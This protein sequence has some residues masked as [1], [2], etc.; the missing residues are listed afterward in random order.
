MIEEIKSKMLNLD[1]KHPFSSGDF[2]QFFNY[3]FH[4][5]FKRYLDK[6]QFYHHLIFR[7]FEKVVERRAETISI[8][9]E[10]FL[11]ICEHRKIDTS[12][13]IDS[14]FQYHKTRVRK[15]TEYFP[16]LK[17]GEAHTLNMYNR[18]GG[19][20]YSH[21]LNTIN[22]ADAI[23]VDPFDLY[24]FCVTELKWKHSAYRAEVIDSLMF[25]GKDNIPYLSYDSVDSN[26]RLS[27]YNLIRLIIEEYPLDKNQKELAVNYYNCIKEL[28]NKVIAIEHKKKFYREKAL[29]SKAKKIPTYVDPKK[30]KAAL[31]E[32]AKLFHPDKNPSGL[33]LFKEFNKHYM[34]KDISN[35]VKM[36][37]D[38][39]RR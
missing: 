1:L 6:P 37:N 28:I 23:L 38:Y 32:G 7:E 8:D 16:S 20:Y 5:D 31:R 34:N 36:I 4:R 10:L 9:R 21:S 12:P 13:F 3:S 33:E 24:K 39:K 22:L 2:F 29:A 30:L 17:K 14:Y 19:K 18:P 27:Y 35:M 26:Y 25:K 11:K 15:S